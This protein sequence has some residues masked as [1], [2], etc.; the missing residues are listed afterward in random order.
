MDPKACIQIFLD[1]LTEENRKEAAEDYN[2]WIKH[3]GY[4]VRFETHPST[5]AWMQ[6]DRYGEIISLGQKSLKVKM[7]RSGL[8]HSV[9][10]GFI[11]W[12]L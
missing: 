11:G 12:L 8:I 1:A 4:A 5:D 2:D 7:D 6:G 9:N 10:V 3:G